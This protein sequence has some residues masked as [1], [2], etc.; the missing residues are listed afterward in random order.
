MMPS[1]SLIFHQLDESVHLPSELAPG[2][3]LPSEPRSRH[4]CF[5]PGFGPLALPGPGYHCSQTC[6][7]EFGDGGK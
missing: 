7:A 6:M 2:Y 5:G 4:L 1:A 3:T